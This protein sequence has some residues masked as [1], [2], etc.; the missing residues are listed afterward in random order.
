MA[1]VRSRRPARLSLPQRRRRSPCY[2]GGCRRRVL[3]GGRYDGIGKAFGR[4][5]P[6]TG[7][8][9]DLRDLARLRRGGEPRAILAPARH[10]AALREAVR[11]LRAAGE[12]VVQALPGDGRTGG[13]LRVRSR[14]RAA[15][16]GNWQRGR[17]RR[18]R[19]AK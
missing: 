14:D 17:A 8:S 13:R 10:D 11:Q 6:A 16:N 12:V 19:P 5:R 4:A 18:R 9:I 2:V 7:F 1:A 15:S 3:R